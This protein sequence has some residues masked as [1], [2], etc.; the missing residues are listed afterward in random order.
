MPTTLREGLP[1]AALRLSGTVFTGA[2][3]PIMHSQLRAGIEG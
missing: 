2:R 3:I 1:V